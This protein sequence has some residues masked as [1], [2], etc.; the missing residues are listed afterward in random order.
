MGEFSGCLRS[1]R[2]Q[3]DGEA[4]VFAQGDAPRAEFQGRN[5]SLQAAYPILSLEQPGVVLA[6]KQAFESEF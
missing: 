3:Q 6:Q 5:D 1:L 4:F 2:T